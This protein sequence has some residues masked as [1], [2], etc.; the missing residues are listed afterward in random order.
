MLKRVLFFLILGYAVAMP[1]VHAQ[2]SPGAIQVSAGTTVLQNEAFNMPLFLQ[3]EAVV[4][5]FLG[6][7][8][9]FGFGTA[10]HK[11]NEIGFDGLVYQERWRY[12]QIMVGTE[13]TFHYWGLVGGHGLFPGGDRL[14]L[15]VT[16]YTGYRFNSQKNLDNFFAFQRRKNRFFIGPVAGGRFYIIKG[17]GVYVEGGRAPSGY[18]GFGLSY[19]FGDVIPL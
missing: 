1:A 6:A 3:G 9:Y 19:K 7:G 17:L 4:L 18:I 14:D 5:D 12:T 10:L 15:Y 13:A 2:L 8:L 11:S 16:L